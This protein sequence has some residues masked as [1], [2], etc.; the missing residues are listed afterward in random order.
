V[1]LVNLVGTRC[2]DG[3]LAALRAWYTD[4]VHLLM[5]CEGLL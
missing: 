2:T 3:N 5:A 4:H 1:R